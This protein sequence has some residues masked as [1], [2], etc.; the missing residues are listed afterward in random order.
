MTEPAT[1]DLPPSAEPPPAAT[2]APASEETHAAQG[3]ASL[4]VLALIAVLATCWLARD[5]LIP[6]M[7]AMFLALIANPLVT[8]LRKLW[9]PRWLGALA[10]VFGGLAMTIFLA[11]LLVAPAADWVRQAPTA[12]KQVA[13]KLRAI[14]LQVEQANKAAASIANAAGAAPAPAA[15][16][17]DKPHAPNLWGAIAKAPQLLATLGAVVLLSYFF[18]V[19]G[20]GLQ[21]QAISLLPDRQKK[22]L[23]TDI[24]RT[25][26][27]DVSN[28]VLTITVIN[29]VLG[30]LLTGALYWLGL[31]LTDALLWGT[32]AA[33][34][35]YAPYVGPLSGVLALGVVGVVAFDEPQR[36]LLPP[37]IFLGLHALESQLVTPIV[38][39]RRMAISP[40]VMLLWLMLWGWLWGIAGLLLAVPMLACFKILSE[41]VDGWEG[42]A[43]VIE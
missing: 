39:G 22:N 37:A 13:P 41:R 4:R 19:Y 33:L 12:L 11:S 28:Y 21:R 1:T 7:L 5:L 35:N 27:A 29:I 24:L 38:L 8:R 32:V 31:S 10:V 42:W 15:V 14:T 43:R 40:L 6:I 26:E 16:T 20:A 17:A 18:L 30:L 34:L 23:T 25:I 36:M 9:I 3:P 2:S